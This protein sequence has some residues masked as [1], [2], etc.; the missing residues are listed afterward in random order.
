MNKFTVLILVSTFLG[1]VYF[2]F[3]VIGSK[4]NYHEMRKEEERSDA[5]EALDFW[6]KSRAYP[7]E[8]IPTDGTTT[9]IHIRN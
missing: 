5:L 8:D 4:K 7:N 2:S 3:N 6:T 9:H 1:S